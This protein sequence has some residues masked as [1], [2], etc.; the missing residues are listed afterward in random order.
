[1]AITINK[2]NFNEII[3]GNNKILVDMWAPWC[4]PCRMLGQILQELDETDEIVLGKI[5]CDEEPELCQAFNVTNIPLL[6]LFENG[7]I[8]KK[9]VGLISKEQVLELYK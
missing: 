8:T 4:G 3:K 1:M 7:K 2:E 6:L 9:S 5:N